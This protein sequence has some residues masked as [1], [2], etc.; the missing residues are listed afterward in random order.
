[1]GGQ[2]HASAALPPEKTRYPL[3]RRL[4]GPQRRSGRVRKISPPTWIRSPDRPARS[5]S[6]YRLQCDPTLIGTPPIR[7][8][9]FHT[10]SAVGAHVVKTV[11]KEIHQF[12]FLRPTNALIYTYK[13]LTH[14]VKISRAAPTCFGPFGPSSGSYR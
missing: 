10:V 3:Y 1:V 7:P 13:M 6:L 12:K 14:T 11:F 4:D 8:A 5:E 9:L 2:R